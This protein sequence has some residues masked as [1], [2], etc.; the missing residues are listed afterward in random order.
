MGETA[1]KRRQ[2]GPRGRRAPSRR[3]SD[4]RQAGGS[5]RRVRGCEVPL[6]GERSREESPT[7]GR[8]G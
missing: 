7:L 8:K 4:V 6:P 3:S 2:D 5:C 1:N